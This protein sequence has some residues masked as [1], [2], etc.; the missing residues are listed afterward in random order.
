MTTLTWDRCYIYNALILNINI[1]NLC[2]K[3]IL[4]TVK[5]MVCNVIQ[6]YFSY[7]VAAIFI[8]GG[9]KRPRRR[10]P[11]CHKSLTNLITWCFIEY[12]SQWTRFELTTLVVI[13]TDCIVSCKSN[14]HTITTTLALLNLLFASCFQHDLSCYIF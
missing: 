5:I 9:N 2:Q 14:Y 10:P 6:Q 11:T 1:F 3:M 4:I 7:I 12:T 13:D 8:G